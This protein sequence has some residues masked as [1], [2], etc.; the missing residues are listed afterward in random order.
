MSRSAYSADLRS[1]EQADGTDP[2]GAAH[3][4]LV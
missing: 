4:H 3:P 2:Y 1:A